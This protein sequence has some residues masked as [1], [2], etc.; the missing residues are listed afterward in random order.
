MEGH[1]DGKI[2]AEPHGPGPS[3]A[4]GSI[5]NCLHGCPEFLQATG[6][7]PKHKLNLEGV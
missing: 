1:R 5:D 6:L 4:G 3:L 7:V 2:T